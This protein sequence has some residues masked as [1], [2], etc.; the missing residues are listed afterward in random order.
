MKTNMSGDLSAEH[1]LLLA[2][3]GYLWDDWALGFRRVR[4]PRKQTVAEYSASQADVISFE[5]LTAHNCFKPLAS[6]QEQLASMKWLRERVKA[7]KR[8][9]RELGEDTRP[10]LKAVP[11]SE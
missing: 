6:V 10:L 2:N 3:A 8:L 11:R 5:E 1:E 9:E 4:D 7:R